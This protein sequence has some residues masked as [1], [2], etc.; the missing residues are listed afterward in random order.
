MTRCRERPS[1]RHLASEIDLLERETI[2]WFTRFNHD[3]PEIQA[4]GQVRTRMD[5]LETA[6]RTL[7]DRATRHGD[8]YVTHQQIAALWSAYLNVKISA[9]DV[10]RLMILLKVA[11][12]QRGNA[13]DPDHAVDIAGYAALLD[14][15]QDDMTT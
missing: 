1:T 6:A 3:Y 15:V 2:R 10:V 9:P 8:C 4:K 5:I 14:R 12:S 13:S 7:T 11:R